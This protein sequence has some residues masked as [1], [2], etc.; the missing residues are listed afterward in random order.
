M[1]GYNNNNTANCRKV[2][3]YVHTYVRTYLTSSLSGTLPY[4]H[5]PFLYY[6]ISDL[7]TT[8]SPPFLYNTVTQSHRWPSSAQ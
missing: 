2:L 3:G 5:S 1:K 8:A 4:A 6:P 7:L